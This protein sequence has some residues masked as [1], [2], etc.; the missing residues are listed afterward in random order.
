MFPEKIK[1]R[2]KYIE[3]QV[4]AGNFE[5]SWVDL[6]YTHDHKS[7]RLRVMSDA[8]IVDGVRVNVSAAFQQRLADLFDASLLTPM[9][10]D[11]IYVNAAR[12]A[13][14]RPQPISSSVS[15]M[16]KHSESV[17]KQLGIGPGLASTVGK[18]WVLDK[19]LESKKDKACNY[20]WHFTGS[21]FQGVKGYP[22]AAGSYLSLKNVSVIQPN[23]TAHDPYHLDYSQICQLVSQQCWVD[24][25]EMRFSS[26]LKDFN[27]GHLVSH[28]GPL[29]IDRQPGTSPVTGQ[30]V[31]FPIDVMNSGTDIC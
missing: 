31:L 9:I 15:A 11:L 4:L 14:P 20:G 22:A 16:L 23:A 10:A 5:A 7:V 25:Q 8:L 18:H 1:D 24:G 29:K 28:Q 19:Q 2:E 30:V 3:D 17:Q 26:L 21:N 6:N 13:D 12:K 27:L